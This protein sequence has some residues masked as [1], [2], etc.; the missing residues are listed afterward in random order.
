MAATSP[1]LESASSVRPSTPNPRE[2]GCS[3][4]QVWGH[5]PSQFRGAWRQEHPGCPMFSWP[6]PFQRERIW[7][8]FPG[9]LDSGTCTPG[10]ALPESRKPLLAKPL[11]KPPPE[12]LPG[13]TGCALQPFTELGPRCVASSPHFSVSVPGNLGAPLPLLGSCPS[14]L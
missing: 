11:S 6:L 12:T 5:R 3:G 8:V 13:P 4:L 10:I 2:P 7:A 9:F 14:S 1:A